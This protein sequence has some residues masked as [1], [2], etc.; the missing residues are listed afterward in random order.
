MGGSGRVSFQRARQRWPQLT[1]VDVRHRGMFS[2]V[3]G[4]LT[5]GTVL[6]LCRLRYI[7]SAHDWRFA[8]YRASHNDY[9]EA[10][11]PTGLPIGTC[12]D[13][14]DTACSFL[15]RRPNRL[16]LTPDE[17]QARPLRYSVGSRRLPFG[18]LPGAA[19]VPLKGLDVQKRGV[20][21]EAFELVTAKHPGD[22]FRHRREQFSAHMPPVAQSDVPV[23]AVQ[24]SPDGA[25][26]A[27]GE[28]LKRHEVNFQPPLTRSRFDHRLTSP[29]RGLRARPVLSGRVHR[30]ALNVPV[31][32]GQS[33]SRLPGSVIGQGMTRA[34]PRQRAA[35]PPGSSR[36]SPPALWM[37]FR[38]E[39]ATPRSPGHGVDTVSR[40]ALFPAPNRMILLI[41]R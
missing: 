39:T 5:D 28:T 34:W 9:N 17:R 31:R 25:Q 26:Q 30:P 40:S 21:A 7:G 8:I 41:C 33:G 29:V 32:L 12:E 36:P 10:I 23:C 6:P 2:Y 1:T 35:E 38:I 16:D 18:A 37:S 4:V 3:D 22:P 27:V 14:L 15:P 13:A 24:I 11:F 19:A 20:N